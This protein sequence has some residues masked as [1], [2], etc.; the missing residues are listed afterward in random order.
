MSTILIV[1]DTKSAREVLIAALDGQGY[2]LITANNGRDALDKALKFKPDLVLLDV[3]MPEMDGYEVCK[4]IRSMPEIAEVP[5]VILTSLDDR[6]SLLRG[7]EAGADD[8]LNKPV[9]RRELMA[10]VRTITRLNR[11]RTLA[12]Q[13]AKLEE[14]A[15]RVISAQ[16][17]E[18][19]RIS[20]E[21]HDDL[22]QTLTILMLDVR[23]LQADLTLP[24]EELFARFE[25]HHHHLYEASVKTRNLAHDLRP[26]MVDTFGLEKSMEIY[27]DKFLA[28]SQLPV[29]LHIEE[30][31]PELPD[32]Y[33][34]I[35]Y[36]ILQ[37]GLNN[38]L[39]HAQASQVWVDLS[40]EDSFISL[41]IQDD[42]KGF[43][44]AETAE[45]VGIIGMR[46]RVELVGG[47]LKYHSPENG[48]CILIA[49]LPVKE[50][51]SIKKE[52]L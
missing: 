34:V 33:N 45:G 18:R 25:S 28:R 37:E 12:E 30:G 31:I 38:I 13:R 50:S 42:G 22:G 20:H 16:E 5:V 49:S 29:F 23:N 43:D 44:P 1:D 4:H 39:K 2:Q 36:R 14:L 46:E 15:S 3:M 7:I 40:S 10:R 48:G 41:I 27:C 19:L 11:Y 6:T 8:F 47:T 24:P 51:S 35:L 21:L 9:D 26:V 52:A 17:Q 32:F